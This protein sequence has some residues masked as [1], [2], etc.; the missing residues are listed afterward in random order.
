MSAA[1]DLWERASADSLCRIIDGVTFTRHERGGGLTPVWRDASGRI[2]L[3]RAY[4][5]ST[6]CYRIDGGDLRQTYRA[7]EDAARAAIKEIGS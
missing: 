7:F 2:E 6:Y 5:G 3:V 1:D 4:R